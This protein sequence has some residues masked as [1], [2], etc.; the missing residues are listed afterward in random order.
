MNIQDSRIHSALLK[1]WDKAVGTKDYVK[2][3]WIE[4]DNAI[5][6]IQMKRDEDAF[7]G[8]R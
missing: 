6:A 3:E 8:Q 2:A 5:R 7:K 4:L 1:V